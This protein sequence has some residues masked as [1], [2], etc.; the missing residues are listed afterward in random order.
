[1]TPK[2]HFEINWPLA[3]DFYWFLKYFQ[4][5]LWPKKLEISQI[6]TRFLFFLSYLITT[7]PNKYSACSSY[8]LVHL[9][10]LL[11]LVTNTYVL[12]LRLI[13]I[14]LCTICMQY[15]H[16]IAFGVKTSTMVVMN[17]LRSCCVVKF[18]FSEK[19]TKFRSYLPIVLTN[20]LIY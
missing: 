16:C 2:G 12:G 19:T 10:E 4:L 13:R 1:M 15:I 8:S 20:Q 6:V 7:V 11:A 18:S 14:Y 9:D 3:N 17:I 5:G